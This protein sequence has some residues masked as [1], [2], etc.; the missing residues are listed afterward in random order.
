MIK[1]GDNMS[2]SKFYEYLDKMSKVSVYSNEY[3][4]YNSLME[5]EFIKC[6]KKLLTTVLK[7]IKLVLQFPATY[8]VDSLDEALWQ[9]FYTFHE[10]PI[11][12]EIGKNDYVV[13]R[14]YIKD[15]DIDREE[16]FFNEYSVG[17]G[18]TEY[19][20]VVF[21]SEEIP[22][23]WKLKVHWYKDLIKVVIYAV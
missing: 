7:K 8:G 1:Y 4:R 11:K 3:E 18:H 10:K 12:V 19:P 17:H 13:I 16:I 15:I 21:S 9:F 2:W 14:L 6:S 23:K 20:Y 22:V 5:A